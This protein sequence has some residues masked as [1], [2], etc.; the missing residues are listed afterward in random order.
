MPRLFIIDSL[1]VVGIICVVIHHLD[2]YINLNAPLLFFHLNLAPSFNLDIGRIGVW[3]FIFASGASLALSN[4]HFDSFSDIRS[5]YK[6]RLLRIY[7]IYWVGVLLSLEL[8]PKIPML[9][10]VDYLR[11]FAGFQIFFITNNDWEKI[12]G[13]YWFIGLIISLYLLYPIVYLAIKKR[14]NISLLL[15][16]S[17]YIVSRLIMW[18]LFPQF[19]GGVDWFPLCRIFEF[20]LGIYVI[21]RGWYPS[22]NSTRVLAFLG[23]LSFYVFIVH[24]VFLHVIA[25]SFQGLFLF[26]VL[27][28]LVACV[29]YLFDIFIRIL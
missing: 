12:N 5:F 21:Q 24:G 29:I 11:N 20:G 18:Y 9:T 6:K 3:L 8:I 19:T 4:N 2:S 22:F 16:F 13:S 26:V 23:V 17:V 27:T 28:L 25:Q 14:P 1:K 15:L 7:P 10:L